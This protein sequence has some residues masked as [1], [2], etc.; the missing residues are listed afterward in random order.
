MGEWNQ[1]GLMNGPYYHYKT[2]D[3]SEIGQNE[4]DEMQLDWGGETQVRE[5]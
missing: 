4:G 5:I 1:T 3:G 2:H